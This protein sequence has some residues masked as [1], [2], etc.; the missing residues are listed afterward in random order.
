M[1]S[2]H[3]TL[4]ACPILVSLTISLYDREDLSQLPMTTW[5]NMKTLSIEFQDEELTRDDVINL[6]QRFPSLK[7]FH[8]YPCLDVDCALLIPRHCPLLKSVQLDIYM[9]SVGVTCIDEGLGSEGITVTNLSINIEDFEVDDDFMD[10]S[11][12]FRQHHS[13][14]EAIEWN[15]FPEG[16]YRHLHQLQYPQLK[17]LSLYTS[18]SWILRNA[19]ILKE[20]KVSS[21]ALNADPTTLNTIPPGLRKLKFK[22]DDGIELAD[23]E[24][25]ARYL[26]RISQQ[27]ILHEF[28]IRFFTSQTYGNVLDEIPRL[29]TLQRLMIGV[30]GEWNP[31]EMER[32]LDSLV[33]GC[34]YLSCLEID[35]MNAPST[36][37]L[38]TL[39]R[40]EC[41]NRFAFSIRGTDGYDSFWDAIRN[42]SQ[43]KCIRMYPANAVSKSVIRNLKEHRRDMKVF[44][45]GIFKRF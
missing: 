4:A 41:L 24:A 43:L 6:C 1:L 26:H 34:P 12:I 30:H 44:V 14:L 22:F 8:L 40:L 38:N 32:F 9:L 31:Y 27:C 25:S 20:L 33:N 2:L 39:K 13:T 42:F 37:S 17:K 29:T 35:C 19:P 3:D 18:G 23:K 45:D 36:Y 11:S 16:D 21:S 5:P 10:I 7:K 15:I 28:G